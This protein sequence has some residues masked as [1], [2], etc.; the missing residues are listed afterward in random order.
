MGA[1]VLLADEMN[2]FRAAGKRSV[3]ETTPAENRKDTILTA[4][5]L[6]DKFSDKMCFFPDNY[7]LVSRG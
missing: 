6:S 3:E 5:N 7:P 4:E 2:A 1:D